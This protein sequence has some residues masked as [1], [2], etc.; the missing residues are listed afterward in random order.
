[1]ERFWEA[2]VGLSGMGAVGAFVVLVLYKEWLKLRIF[3]TL[4]RE[5]AF[6]LMRLFLILSFLFGSSAV[7]T[8]ILDRKQ[9][10]LPSKTTISGVE[11]E[12]LEHKYSVA[13]GECLALLGR[14]SQGVARPIF[15]R[16]LDRLGLP[17]N[18]IRDLYRE[19]GSLDE[20]GLSGQLSRDDFERSR[21]NLQASVRARVGVMA[22]HDAVVYSDFGYNLARLM[23]LC[24]FRESRQPGMEQASSAAKF[25]A[26]LKESAR[27]VELPD[28]LRGY[29]D[30]MSPD[31][32]VH[33]SSRETMAKVL[34]ETLDLFEI[35]PLLSHDQKEE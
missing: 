18:Q 19:Y 6:R 15:E 5:Q 16:C 28:R 21:A 23:L 32:L 29:I 12:K 20:Y 4:T 13:L 35:D 26:S 9:I 24:Q 25:V 1:M 33:V 2:A 8:Y 3:P 31:E 27:Q 30:K 34:S 7:L 11:R 14:S 10:L 17:A 22:G